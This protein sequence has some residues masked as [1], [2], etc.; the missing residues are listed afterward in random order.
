MPSFADDYSDHHTVFQAQY[1]LLLCY[2][3]RKPD[4]I[5][6]SHHVE[7]QSHKIVIFGAPEFGP[8]YICQYNTLNIF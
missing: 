1:Y 4:Q 8:R 6:N 5:H 7:C 2:R 3:L